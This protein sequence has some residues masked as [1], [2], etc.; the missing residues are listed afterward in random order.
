M[1]MNPCIECGGTMT[2]EELN[3][4][5]IAQRAAAHGVF[6]EVTPTGEIAVWDT[7]GYTLEQDGTVYVSS[8][9]IEDFLINALQNPAY[10]RS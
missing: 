4:L 7:A 2:Q 1:D 5:A 10:P 6:A 8:N 9:D 3:K